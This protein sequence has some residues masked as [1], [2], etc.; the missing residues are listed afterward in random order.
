MTGR[1]GFTI[2]GT[3]CPAPVGWWAVR[4]RNQFHGVERRPVGVERR[5]VLAFVRARKEVRGKPVDYFLALI[6]AD[7]GTELVLAETLGFRH[8][9]YRLPDEDPQVSWR[10]KA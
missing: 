7:A 1:R 3:P 10:P 6:P 8:L 9:D 5:P 4:P 2:L